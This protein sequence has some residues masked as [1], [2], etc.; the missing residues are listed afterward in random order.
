M[1]ALNFLGLHFFMILERWSSGESRDWW[2]ATNSRG[3]GERV[4]REAFAARARAASWRRIRGEVA[5]RSFC[6]RVA[7][8]AGAASAARARRD[9]DSRGLNRGP[10]GYQLNALAN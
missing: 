7:I 5:A 6:A 2:G 8:A 10:F 1:K 3:W 4:A 9:R